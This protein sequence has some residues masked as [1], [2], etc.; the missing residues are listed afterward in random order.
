MELKS[1]VALITGGG[2]GLGREI[3]HQLAKAGM[4]IAI[5]YAHSAQDA[6]ATVSEIQELGVKAQAFQCDLAAPSA[7]SDIKNMLEN[8]A[9]SFGRLDLLINNAGVTKFVPFSN[10]EGLE[11]EDWDFILKVNTKVPFF[12]TRA[13][14]AIM[15]Q[16]GGGQV[17]NTASVAGMRPS[18]S[19]IAYAASKAAMIHLTKCLAVALAP[20]IRVNAV[21]PGLLMTRWGA[22]FSD[23]AIRQHTEQTPL[24]RIASLEDTAATYLM[25]ARNE[26]MTGQVITVDSG[27]SM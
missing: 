26:S 3:A 7:V 17:I 16:N 23:E 4:D 21:A 9:A 27:V 5:N 12:A 25:L 14:A 19:S 22:K 11:E 6:V 24:K 15:R 1:K 13:A 10:L 20:D 8:V 2:T 18:G